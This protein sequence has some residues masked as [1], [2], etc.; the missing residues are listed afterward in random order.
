[1]SER[2]IV[3]ELSDQER[4]ELLRL[5]HSQC[6]EFRLVQRAKII[7]NAADGVNNYES[8]RRLG[9]YVQTVRKWIRR[10]DIR[11]KAR[12]KDK[13][14]KHL[15]DAKRKGCPPTF[16]AFFWVD[17]MSVATSVPQESGRPIT[18]WTNRELAEEVVERNLVDSIHPTT[19]GRF[20]AECDLKPH[21]VRGWMNRK[22]D[23]EFDQR[24]S[25]VKQCLVNATSEDGVADEIAVS[26]DEKTGMQAK[27]RIAE[28]KPMQP[29]RPKKLEFEYERHGT[30]VLFAMMIVNTGKIIGCMR[31]NRPNIV[32]AEV[33]GEMFRKLFNDG[34]KRIHVVLDQL[35]TH[36]SE[37]LVRT[38]AH[39]CQV[40]VDGPIEKGQQRRVWL[41]MPNK[42]IVFHFTPKHASWLN[43]VEIW[44]GVL[45]RKLLR[46]GSFDSIETLE[47]QVEQ[48]IDYYNQRMSHPYRFKRWKEEQKKQSTD[49]NAA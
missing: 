11:R 1:M 10:Y 6:Q 30:L 35:N 45:V 32:T 31:L 17:V 26:F 36:W 5:S 44:F 21:R 22:E 20:L 3:I 29:G 33:L 23:P 28:D 24:A 27:E 41:S 48:F 46:H 47:D 12:P 14:Q 19:I 15:A 16:D 9:I 43:P 25:D 37:I 38:V 42:A 4:E 13:I 2:A 18:E 8:A 39:L 49:R 40:D 34:Y 7:L